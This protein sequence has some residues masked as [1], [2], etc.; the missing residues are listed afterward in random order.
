MNA[1]LPSLRPVPV[2][3]PL[4]S[5]LLAA[6]LPAPGQSYRVTPITVPG[7][8][9]ITVKAL[10]QAGQVAGDYQSGSPAC[11]AFRWSAGTATDLG[12]L[13]GGSSRVFSLNNLGDVTGQSSLAGDAGE[14][15]FLHTGGVMMNLGAPGAAPS[16]GCG[17]NDLQQVAGYAQS[18]PGGPGTRSF[19]TDPG[20]LFMDLGTLGGS[21]SSP[22]AINLPGQVVGSS[23]TWGDA[24]T[25]AFVSMGGMMLDLGTLG[26]TFSQATAINHFGQITG[27][28]RT[29]GDAGLH[30][31]V[32]DSWMFTGMTDLGTLG[33]TSSEGRAIN[34][35]GQ[36]IGDSTTAG[37]LETHAFLHTGGVMLDLGTLGGGS[38]S[39][40]GLNDAGQ[41]VGVSKSASGRDRAFLWQNGVLLDL[42][43]RLPAGSGWEL[44]S[45][46]FINEAGHIVG[47]GLFNGQ[48]AWFMLAPG[49]DDNQPPVARAG[50]DQSFPCAAGGL[51]VTLDA[52]T[53]NDPDG[54][55]LNFQWTQAGVVVGTTAALEI[56]LAP[57]VHTLTVRVTDT[58]GASAEDTVEVTVGDTFAPALT[59]PP[60]QTATAGR[61][62][63]AKV[64]NFLANLMTYDNCTATGA[65][66]RV[67][68]PPA[69]TEVGC[70]LHPV[71]I[72][73]TDAA[74]NSA[75]CTTLFT[76]VDRKPPVIHSLTATPG[77]LIHGTGMVPVT[78]T[79]QATD[80]CDPNP[81]SRIVS[82]RS[83][84]PAGRPSDRISS[85]WR[86]TG[87]LTVE[88]LAE[89]VPSGRPRLYLVRIECVDA[90]GNRTQRTRPIVVRPAV[91]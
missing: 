41:V 61:R 17:I 56:V 82:V 83:T 60:G 46:E 35:S 54:D 28:A 20:G 18:G 22:S 63:T 64:P 51:R 87:P 49:S 1:P 23:S 13:G 73:V 9:V 90:S 76:V 71:T 79:V 38:S 78:F 15:A 48:P 39:A 24:T 43:T 74:G 59:C 50:E 69:G 26:G 8:T 58:R 66:V 12:T 3:L 42:N 25:N 14:Q 57:G 86:I 5:L 40:R 55:A 11:R 2:L 32:V 68:N 88:L 77:S 80:N 65:L 72:T 91:R 52:S 47:R 36:V 67:Q 19:V 53:S 27:A 62:G 89:R 4:G 6:V 85:D 10:N 70:G 30:A 33:G 44:Q 75:A 16:V 37:D 81:V 45:A 7:A 21:F 34:A 29:A 84:A 31:F